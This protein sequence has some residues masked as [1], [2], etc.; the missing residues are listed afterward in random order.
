M[1]GSR[2]ISA[3][4]G[5]GLGLAVSAAVWYFFDTVLLFVFLPFIPI[6]FWRQSPDRPLKEC[7]TCDFT[8]R[9]PTVA[10]CPRDGSRLIEAH[11][12]DPTDR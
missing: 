2:S 3:L 4:A 5:L 1:T 11:P 6:W 10:Y 8:A 12:E 9:D 7:P